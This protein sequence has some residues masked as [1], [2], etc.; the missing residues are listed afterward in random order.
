MKLFT[1]THCGEILYFENTQCAHCGYVTGIFE[2]KNQLFALSA[3]D[4]D[5]FQHVYGDMTIDLAYC[6][7]HQFNVCNWLAPKD[8]SS[9][10]CKACMLNRTIPNLKQ[11]QYRGYWQTIERAKHRLVYSLLR[12]QLPI[13]RK[14]KNMPGGLCFDFVADEKNKK[15]YT[16]HNKGL[17][18][19]NIAE[20]D[21][22][23]REMMRKNMNEAYRTVLG[24][25]R[26][27]VGHYYWDVLIANNAKIDE[28]RALFG[29]ERQ[30]YNEAL[31][32]HYKNGAPL[33]WM[34]NYISAY[35]SSHPWEDWAETWAHYMH[36]MDTLET[37]YYFGL[38]ITPVPAK[39]AGMQASVNKDPY[40]E[41]Q[42]ASII[43]QWLPVTYAMNSLNRSMGIADIYPFVITPV[44]MQ[45]LSFIHNTC[46]AEQQKSK[47]VTPANNP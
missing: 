25:F 22:I 23:K 24:H 21:D 1:C 41:E 47:L 45:K 4:E 33:N 8:G 5:S 2:E 39:S 20:A 38:H 34:D 11:Q 37:A 14:K 27:E 46:Y 30:D 9:R 35:A 36:I 18:T 3:K 7:N 42:F 15:I 13:T 19:I 10:F 43:N 40:T 32:Q 6:A 31:Q 28:Y 16:G 44:V 17:I 12:L 26:H 29:D